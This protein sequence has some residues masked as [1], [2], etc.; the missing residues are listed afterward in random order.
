MNSCHEVTIILSIYGSIR[1]V[2]LLVKDFSTIVRW[3]KASD[4][5]DLLF[6]T[7]KFEHSIVETI[8]CSQSLFF[9]RFIFIFLT[10]LDYR[11]I[12]ESAF[13]SNK[14]LIDNREL[15]LHFLN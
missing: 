1:I 8:L 9:R 10:V 14:I 11:G 6:F 2:S 5:D 12:P 4:C 3:S 15:K 7:I 13:L